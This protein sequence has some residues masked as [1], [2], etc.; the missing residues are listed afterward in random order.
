MLDTCSALLNQILCPSQSYDRMTSMEGSEKKQLIEK[1]NETE[2][3]DEEEIT[4]SPAEVSEEYDPD[5][6][7]C[8]PI[9]DR[10]CTDVLCLGLLIGFVVLWLMIA[11]WGFNNG[12]PSKLMYPTD[13]FGNICGRGELADKPHLM[14]F[15]LTK[16]LSL[17]SIAGN[18]K[19]LIMSEMLLTAI[20]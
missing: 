17:T 8:G 15:D 16:C 20:I 13:S 10:S 2:T 14:F 11:L 3:K 6:S 18:N 19:D 4:E 7:E 12:D 5:K 9:K 1:S